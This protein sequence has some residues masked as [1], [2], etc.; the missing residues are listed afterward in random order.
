MTG[1]FNTSKKWDAMSNYD[2]VLDS[3]RIGIDGC[4]RAINACIEAFGGEID[5]YMSKSGGAHFKRCIM[6]SESPFLHTAW[7]L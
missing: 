3:S 6:Q 5:H 7:N 4:A 1:G 2:M